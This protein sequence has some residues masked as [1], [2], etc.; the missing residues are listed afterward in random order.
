MTDS[1]NG[2]Y[3]FA[4]DTSGN[5]ASITSPDMKVR[6]FVYNEAAHTQNTALPNSL[7]GI[8]D[9]NG[10]RFATFEY[11]T[12][13][14]AVSTEHAGGAQKYMLEYTSPGAATTV[15]DALGVA[16][17]YGLTT[18]LGVV[19]G[20]GI[21]GAACPTCGPAAQSHDANGNVSSRTDWNGNRTNYAYDLARNLETS[22]T[23]GLTSAGATTPQTRTINTAWHPTFRLP[24]QI[25]EPLRITTNVYDPDGT[26]C[27]ARGALCSRTIQ[28]TT[29]AN[30]SQGFSATPTGNPRTWTYTYNANGSTAD[31]RRPAHRC[32]GRHDLHL[33]RRRRCRSRQARQRRDDHQCRR[34]SRPSITAYNAHGQPLTI[35][36]PNGDDHDARLRC[37]PAPDLAQRRR[38]GH[39]L[40]LRQR[41]PAR[42][43]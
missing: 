41:G 5:L 7:T 35:V 36:D 11:D 14:R 18:L 13:G 27:G 15:T 9:E 38:R 37:A 26:Q 20:T 6:Q 24:T 31:R 25:A 40:R 3:I 4:Y 10:A 2:N 32:L 42:P 29:D 17:T 39:E 19:K 30:G 22:R 23:E 34:P 1:A 43:R 16:R 8:I 28:A 33:L 12:Q 21:T